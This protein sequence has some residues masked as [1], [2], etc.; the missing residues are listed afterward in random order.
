MRR[1][2]VRSVVKAL[3]ITL[4]VGF[5]GAQFM[6][7]VIHAPKGWHFPKIEVVHE[8]AAPAPLPAP[9]PPVVAAP[10]DTVPAPPPPVAVAP[11]PEPV[12]PK[13][14]TR[15]AKPK[16]KSELP[17]EDSWNAS[18]P[19]AMIVPVHI[20]TEIELSG[21]SERTPTPPVPEP[22]AGEDWPVVCG[23]V[24]DAAGAGVDGASVSI[25][26]TDITERTD[27]NGRFCVVSPTRKITLLV[28]AD[29]RESV[30]YAVELEGHTTQVSVT[31]R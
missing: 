28:G 15:H 23:Q 12:T 30:R 13:H 31:L 20:T 1:S 22:K 27:K 19:T 4:L 9:P 7:E 18:E 16:P 17:E 5:V 3:V 26:S 6:P 29:G 11:P 14:V 2:I 25:E 10:R 21:D 24:V 8:G